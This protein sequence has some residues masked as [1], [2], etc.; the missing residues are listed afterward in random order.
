MRVLIF[1]FF[2]ISSLLASCS[3]SKKGPSSRQLRLAIAE[4]PT[5]LDP[6]KG[7]DVLSTH[8]HLM[9][10]EG[11]VKLHPDGSVS[12]AQCSFYT[13]SSDQ[14]TY[15]FHLG[16]TKW[17][18][19]T[20]VTSYD[21]EKAWKDIL[22]P[23]FPAPNAH[24][25]YCIKQA[26]S[27]KKGLVDVSQVGIYAPSYDILIVELETPTPYFLQLLSFCVFAPTYTKKQQQEHHFI[28]NGP[29]I[30][31]KWMHENEILLEQ[32]PYYLGKNE[33]RL[34]S[35]HLSIIRDETTAVQMYEKGEI[36][37]IGSPFF[38]PSSEA[39]T[40]IPLQEILTAPVAATI[41]IT[42]NTQSF[43]FSNQH[44]RQAFSL[45]LNRKEIVQ[46]ALDCK[47]KAAQSAIPPCLIG[48]TKKTFP[49]DN[50][51]TEAINLF[52]KALK[53]LNISAK[54]LE[55]K[56]TYFYSSSHSEQRLAQILQE[57]WL[58][59]L[60]IK[61]KIQ[62]IERKVLLDFLSKK[63]Y[64]FAQTTCRAQYCDPMS[65]L[66]RFAYKENTKNYPSWENPHYQNL[67]KQS[68]SQSGIERIQTLEKAE[69]ILLEEMPLSPLLHLN[70]HYLKKPY[71][72]NIEL[73]PA[74]GIFFE[75]LSLELP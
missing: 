1:T 70:L 4:D 72:K 13:L 44:L 22:S 61:I 60:G 7:V 34:D 25:L 29:F 24:L 69:T 31:T 59:I 6:R 38:T 2:I 17:S 58:K 48:D 73:S 66:E 9:L 50:N 57:Q 68:T 10:F 30:L 32:N 3:P 51:K 63:N 36:D 67:L 49:L 47:E 45:A 33:I 53:E 71:L 37:L 41:Y 54:E 39:L 18:D 75:R 23:L 5:T 56:I 74:G 43:P 65:I 62:S 15:T 19:G 20:P 8:L 14:K 55:N 12:P 26:E 21:F 42:F 35:I 11:L 46:H 52:K 27:A 16:H 64:F 40:Y 28:S